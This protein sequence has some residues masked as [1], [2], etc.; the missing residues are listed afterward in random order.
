MSLI[1]FPGSD[2]PTDRHIPYGVDSQP[3]RALEVLGRSLEYLIDS[4]MYMIDQPSTRADTEAVS[5]LA[6]LSRVVFT[7]CREMALSVNQ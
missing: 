7:E 5:I 4:R 2:S 3:G 1:P 6:K